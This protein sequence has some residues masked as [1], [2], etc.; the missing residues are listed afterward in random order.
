[1]THSLT[2]R[3]GTYSSVWTT[4]R[5]GAA[6][7]AWPVAVAANIEAPSLPAEK[8]FT[9][10]QQSSQYQ[11]C[12]KYSVAIIF[13]FKFFHQVDLLYHVLPVVWPWWSCWVSE[14]S[15]VPS[16]LSS[17]IWTDICFQLQ[18][19]LNGTVR[20]PHKLNWLSF[21]LKISLRRIK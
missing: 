17:F 12:R 2:E 6:G 3:W 4:P 5:L 20:Q 7:T 1:M 14:T 16:F 13:Q 18:I 11:C 19:F 8:H 10:R 9:H 15:R 21:L